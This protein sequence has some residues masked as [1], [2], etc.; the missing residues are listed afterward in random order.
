MPPKSHNGDIS[1]PRQQR[2][3]RTSWSQYSAMVGWLKTETNFALITGGAQSKLKGV[4][5][6]AKLKKKDGYE[7]LASWVN[8]R[9]GT[10]WS[11]DQAASRYEAYLKLY[12]K[13]KAELLDVTGKKFG[14]GEEDFADN[15][16]V[17]A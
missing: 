15:I 16:P 9:C 6:G 17:V 8:E 14:L 7:S 10:N 1:K 4:Q 3:P 11:T 12:K 2:G 13:T 5:A